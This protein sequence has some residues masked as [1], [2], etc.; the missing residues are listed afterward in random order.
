MYISTSALQLGVVLVPAPAQL[1]E[2]LEPGL[3]GVVVG[4]EAARVHPRR[5][6]AAPSSTVTTR[7]AV[8]A[9]SSRSWLTYSTVLAEPDS[10]SSSQRLPGTSRK[11]SGSSSS[12]TSSG[13][14]SSA[15]STSRFCSPPDSV[16]TSRYRARSYGTPERGRCS[17]R[18][19]RPRRRSRRR[20]RTRPARR[21]SASGCARRRA[22]S[23]RSS[24]SSTRRR[25]RPHP[26]RRHRQ[27]QVAHG[28]VDAA[29]G[30]TIWRITPS[31]PVRVTVPACGA[32]SPVTMRSSVVLPAPLAPTRATLAPSPTRKTTSSSSTRPSGSSNR[33]PASSTCPTGDQSACP[34]GAAATTFAARCPDLVPFGGH[35][36]RTAHIGPGRTSLVPSRG[37]NPCPG[38]SI[39]RAWS[40]G[41]SASPDLEDPEAL[42]AGQPLTRPALLA[43]P[44]L[45][46]VGAEV[47]ADDQH[48]PALAGR[49]EAASGRSSACTAGLPMRM[50]GL[51]QISSNATSAGTLVAA[52][53]PAP[54]RRA[55]APPRWPGRSPAHARSRRPPTPALGQRQRQRDR[56]QARSRSPGR[57]RGA[58]RRV[59]RGRRA[60]ARRC[61]GRPG[62][63]RTRR[64]P[65]AASARAPT[66]WPATSACRAGD[67][68]VAARS[69]ARSRR[70]LAGGARGLLRP[71]GQL[72]VGRVADLLEGEPVRR[73]PPAP[74]G[75]ARR[76]ARMRAGSSTGSRPSPTASSAPI[77]A[78]TM[79]WQKASAT[80]VTSTTPAGR[81][82]SSRRRVRTV[83][84]ALARPAER[85][86][87]VL[88]QQA[89]PPRPFITVALT[90]RAPGQHMPARAAG[91]ACSRPVADP[92]DVAPP[93]RGEPG[94]EARRGRPP[95]PRT[96]TSSGSAALS[97]AA[98]APSSA[99]RGPG[100]RR[101]RPGR[102][103]ARPRRCGRRR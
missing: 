88:A 52:C 29:P 46:R 12:S 28:P 84:R 56:Q 27:Q 13:P 72:V 14:R 80:T 90:G 94:V 92:V 64:W 37:A 8:R 20:R 68:G 50:G 42:G 89:R 35:Q 15:S 60:P 95:R 47:A 19:R 25:G 11:L 38:T 44:A 98:P 91:R 34:D 71:R 18:P 82:G 45:V 4:R 59:R 99:G 33:M 81:S 6:P 96:T 87:V 16:D 67:A 10:R 32:S 57:G 23:A 49:A 36:P 30:C 85:G 74:A 66:P 102:A 76:A 48:R 103:R 79:L 101:A 70:R 75:R 65:T 24:S 5:L 26:R 93:H 73:Q 61:R 40:A 77:S 78:R 17:R 63:A 2:P 22:P 51:D 100:R 53:T 83:R 41:G 3:A 21:R 31:P 39:G 55:G 97:R 69:S 7:V 86:E 62:R 9:S 43:Q 58:R 54:G 1:L